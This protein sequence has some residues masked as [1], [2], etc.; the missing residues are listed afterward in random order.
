[1]GNGEEV[2]IDI[3]NEGAVEI[4]VTGHP[5][6]SCTDVTKAIEKALG[7]TVDRKKTAEYNLPETKETNVQ[8]QQI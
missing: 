2:T 6:R 7:T 4:K 5:G 8:K 3:D 1:M